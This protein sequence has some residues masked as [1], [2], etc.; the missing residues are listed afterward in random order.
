MVTSAGNLPCKAVIHAVGLKF[1]GESMKQFKLIY[2]LKQTI[3][4]IL[5]QVV[6]NDYKSVSIPVISTE[7][8]KLSI[9]QFTASWM[10]AVLKFIDNDEQKM[11]NRKLI[12]CYTDSNIKEQIFSIISK[13]IS[14][15]LERKTQEEEKLSIENKL[16]SEHKNSDDN[17]SSK[18]E[19]QTIIIKTKKGRRST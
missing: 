10:K 15:H 19:T 2:I 4:S 8:S 14:S 9:E 13:E 17:D 5:E 3:N 6:Q 16:N 1:S 12:L 11:K 18:N 7:D